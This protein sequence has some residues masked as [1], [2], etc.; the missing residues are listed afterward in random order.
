MADSPPVQLDAGVGTT[1]RPARPRPRARYDAKRLELIDIA[2][3]LYARRG[4]HATS[5]DDLVGATGLQRG[6]L[7]HYIDGKQDLLVAIHERFIEPLLVASRAICAES[8]PPEAAVRRLARALM[9]AIA[10]YHDHVTV[11]LNDWSAIDEGPGWRRIQDARREFETI[12]ESVLAE[13]DRQ[14]VF[15]IAETRLATMAFLG[16]INYSYQWY[17]PAGPL[18][19]DELAERLVHIFLTGV[20]APNGRPT[21]PGGAAA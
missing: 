6:G 5:I 2:A 13:G 7:Y 8:L 18:S 16:M 12:V 14:R 10:T 9:D 4:Y 17:D 19:P 1:K 3:G 20:V 11:F 21:S 15:S